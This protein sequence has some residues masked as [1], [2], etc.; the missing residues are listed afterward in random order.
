[1]QNNFNLLKSKADDDNDG[2]DDDD[3]DE[4]VNGASL[5]TPF[6]CGV[7]AEKFA[8]V[9]KLEAHVGKKHESN[10][11]K[12]SAAKKS[13]VE[14]TGDA[15]DEITNDFVSEIESESRNE[16]KPAST[17]LSRRLVDKSK[18]VIVK[19]TEKDWQECAARNW[20]AEFGYGNPKKVEPS[21][22]SFDLIS[23]M[24]SKFF[25]DDDE[26]DENDEVRIFL[27][28]GF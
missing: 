1:M 12:A 6:V 22:R 16:T 13:Q 17:E 21:K 23:K 24:K 3:D 2:G 26:E 5:S 28:N 25:S 10:D 19:P 15:L 8:S 18:I 4:N 9:E 27:L 11:T 14:L 7:C 20:A